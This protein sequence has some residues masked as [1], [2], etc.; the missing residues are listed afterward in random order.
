MKD[1]KGES[2]KEG[3]MSLK[4][5]LEFLCTGEKSE[6]LVPIAHRSIVFE[7]NQN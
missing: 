7:I 3:I 2:W 1:M 4:N 6:N 5:D